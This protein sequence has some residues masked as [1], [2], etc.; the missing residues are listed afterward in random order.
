MG[1]LASCD[2][3]W[4]C[5]RAMPSPQLKQTRVIRFCP[6]G[7]FVLKSPEI[8]FYQPQTFPSFKGKGCSCLGERFDSS[9]FQKKKKKRKKLN[10][11][12]Q[13]QHGGKN[14][15]AIFHLQYEGRTAFHL[16]SAWRWSTVGTRLLEDHVC[17]CIYMLM[18]EV[19]MMC[20]VSGPSLTKC[21]PEDPSSGLGSSSIWDKGSDPEQ[22][23]FCRAI[24]WQL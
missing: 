19:Q 4:V 7:L 22:S 8:M 12:S 14:R 2:G 18:G 5:K 24:L 16:T 20:S 9:R 15:F 23:P 21:E 10:G 6:Q 13:K 1:Q 3:W 11:P 17:V